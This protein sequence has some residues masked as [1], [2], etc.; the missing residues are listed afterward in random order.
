MAHTITFSTTIVELTIAAGTGTVVKDDY[1]TQ[2]TSNAKGIVLFKADATHITVAEL[3]ANNFDTTNTITAA[4]SS[5]TCTASVRTSPSGQIAAGTV[6]ANFCL[7]EG[8]DSGVTNIFR[9]I[10]DTATAGVTDPSSSSQWLD[11]DMQINIGRRGQSSATVALS[12]NEMLTMTTTNTAVIRIIGKSGTTSTLRLGAASDTG[13][14]PRYVYNGS[15]V[16]LLGAVDESVSSVALYVDTYGVF[17]FFDSTFLG[18]ETNLAYPTVY[19]TVKFFR[20]KFHGMGGFYYTSTASI[21]LADISITRCDYAMV[22]SSTPVY[23]SKIDFQDGLSVTATTPI[24]MCS[25]GYSWESQ[26]SEVTAKDSSGNLLDDWFLNGSAYDVL[27]VVDSNVDSDGAVALYQSG[28]VLL[29]ETSLDLTVL[30]EAGTAIQGATVA[31]LDKS[32][33][34]ALFSLL[35]S[36]YPTAGCNL[37]TGLTEYNYA[38][39]CTGWNLNDISGIAVGDIIRIDSEKMLITAKPGLSVTSR[40]NTSVTARKLVDSSGNFTSSNVTVGARVR[41][42]TDGTST[43]VANID[44]TTT[45]SLGAHIFTATSKAYSIDNDY[46]FTCTRSYGSSYGHRH[47]SNFNLGVYKAGVATTDASGNIY[48]TGT[49]LFKLARNMQWEMKNA[50]TVLQTSSIDFNPFTIVVSKSGYKTYTSKF[51]ISDTAGLVLIVT[52]AKVKDFNESKMVRI[53]TQ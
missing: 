1:I 30:D 21:Y 4:D 11:L 52:L 2:A 15:K 8:S 45:L 41:N 42:T 27:H 29:T 34:N 38:D 18:D 22:P 53:Y 46:A 16:N 49:T 6:N 28:I 43:I 12:Q 3:D 23:T 17:E 26:F 20:S 32:G 14:P 25:Y 31:V 24:V 44:S 5:A 33:T 37:Y 19:G 7:V 36:T 13:F 40:T 48:M 9:Q 35:T 39:T 51:S 47:T 50:T 10:A